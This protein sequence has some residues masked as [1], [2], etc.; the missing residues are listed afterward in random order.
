MQIINLSVDE[1][2]TLTAN[3][4]KDVTFDQICSYFKKNKEGYLGIIYSYTC[5]R[6]GKK[7][8]G[9][10]ANP[11]SRHGTH[12]SSSKID[13]QRSDANAPFYKAL[14][15][16]TLEGFRYNV[17]RVFHSYNLSEFKLMLDVTEQHFIRLFQTTDKSK[18]YNINAG[19]KALPIGATSYWAK[20]VKQYSKSGKFIR[21]YECISE[22]TRITKIQGSEISSVCSHDSSRKT[23][24]GYLWTYS[25]DK[26]EEATIRYASKDIIH[27]YTVD[28]EYLDS[29][30]SI[31]SASLCV[32]GD[33]T[34][35]LLC[36]KPPCIHV[37][38]GYR[39]SKKL[40]EQLPEPAVKLNVP[41]YKYDR[42]GRYVTCYD[43]IVEGSKSINSKYSTHLGICLTD[44]W[45]KAGGY[46]WRTFK[47]ASI[48]IPSKQRR[49]HG[50]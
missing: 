19:G 6:D 47:A 29:F 27:R 44:L 21:E 43:S 14:R 20:S 12:I 13:S 38:Y 32:N 46:Y 15:E 36:S 42:D 37:A 8:V 26:L 35:I 50:K 18:G 16:E 23:A 24:G 3:E 41:V 31:K 22:A 34:R 2:S 7:Y 28:G 4:L 9:Q 11:R 5:V 10:T 49:H 30:P 39:W 40:M 25:E 1:I 17:L 45:R 48:E 33:S